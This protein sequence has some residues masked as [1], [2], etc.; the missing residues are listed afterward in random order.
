MASVREAVALEAPEALLTHRP[1]PTD[2][3]ARAALPYTGKA[4]E[5]LSE[6]RTRSD[7]SSPTN[8][9]TPS[10]GETGDAR[11]WL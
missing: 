3:A 5:P 11:G 10:P 6:Q 2:D 8:R 9:L 4:G 1:R 7:T